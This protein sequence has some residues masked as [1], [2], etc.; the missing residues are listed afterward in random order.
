M[1]KVKNRL[2]SFKT[3]AMK[4]PKEAPQ[5]RTNEDPDLHQESNVPRAFDTLR[6]QRNATWKT[7]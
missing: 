4:A 7:A 1:T 3:G 6:S 2:I 5:S